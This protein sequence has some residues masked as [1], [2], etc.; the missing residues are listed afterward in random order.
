MNISFLSSLQ[1]IWL[2]DWAL[3][4]VQGSKVAAFIEFFLTLEPYLLPLDPVSSAVILSGLIVVVNGYSQKTISSI[5]AIMN[6]RER[7]RE[8]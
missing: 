3:N 6:L 2:F 8:R 4:Q 1:R 7:V 5:C